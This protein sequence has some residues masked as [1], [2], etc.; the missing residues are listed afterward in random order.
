[1]HKTLVRVG[2]RVRVVA[3]DLTE[4]CLYKKPHYQLL[5]LQLVPDP[6][7]W[8]LGA[9]VLKKNPPLHPAAMCDCMCGNWLLPV[10][11]RSGRPRS[12]CVDR[13]RQRGRFD[14]ATRV[15]RVSRK[16]QKGPR[17]TT[18]LGVTPQSNGSPRALS[19]GERFFSS[20][21]DTSAS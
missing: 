1:M 12:S 13:F 5:V 15:T 6:L 7:E 19:C 4:E 3:G 8:I 18:P 20:E 17:R 14:L 10:R 21:T 11:Q 9:A 16:G 2:E